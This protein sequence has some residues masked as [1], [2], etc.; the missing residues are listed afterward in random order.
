MSIKRT[1]STRRSP[2]LWVMLAVCLLSVGCHQGFSS[3]CYKH[4]S[5]PYVCPNCDARSIDQCCCF[6][7]TPN[8]GYNETTW[9]SMQS[10]YQS[11]RNAPAYHSGEPVEIEYSTEEIEYSPAP[12]EYSEKTQS[13]AEVPY[14]EEMDYQEEIESLAPPQQSLDQS[15]ASSPGAAGGVVQVSAAIEMEEESTPHP[16]PHRLPSVSDAEW[17]TAPEPAA[18]ARADDDEGQQARQP[19]SEYFRAARQ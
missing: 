9:A 16:L 14:S 11:I 12:S 4:L 18:D 3:R 1:A 17:V 15:D 5:N 2:T 7:D 6:P 19:L 13:S 8:A 10:P